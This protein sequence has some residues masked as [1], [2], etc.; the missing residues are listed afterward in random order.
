MNIMIIQIVKIPK[1]ITKFFSFS[2][3]LI[4]FENLVCEIK[5]ADEIISFLVRFLTGVLFECFH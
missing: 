4:S 3:M 2:G 1:R 5:R